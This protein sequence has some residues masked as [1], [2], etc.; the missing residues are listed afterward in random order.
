[1]PKTF[2]FQ[3]IV[4]VITCNNQLIGFINEVLRELFQRIFETT[5]TTLRFDGVD[6]FFT[7]LL[8]DRTPSLKDK[9][10]AFF[11]DSE[12]R[13]FFFECSSTFAGGKLALFYNY[14]IIL[15]DY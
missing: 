10:G 12:R 4:L 8:S 11:I 9:T 5:E 13:L 2:R 14:Y 6:N 1:M 3:Q 15:F 7:A